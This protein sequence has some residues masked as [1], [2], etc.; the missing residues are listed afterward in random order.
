M[1][2]WNGEP[3]AVAGRTALA[4][5]ITTPANPY[6]A[7]NAVNQV[8]AYLFGTGLVEPLDDL[9]GVNPPS[10]PELLDELAT[11][12][13]AS[14][15]DIKYLLKAIARTRV[16]QLSSADP[17]G[18]VSTPNPRLF[19]RAAVRALTGD[20]LYDSLC[21]AAGFDETAVNRQGPPG[22]VTRAE[23]LV[24]FGRSDRP[25]HAGRTILQSLLFMNGGL[26]AD[27]IEPRKGRML[28][29]IAGAPFLDTT[30]RIEALYLAAL[31]RRPRPDESQRLTDF[32]NGGGPAH[33]SGRAWRPCF[34]HC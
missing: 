22:G 21:L 24:R 8:W 20:Q 28:A 29:A 27:A 25:T 18:S 16:Y 13:V 19:G 12:F 1:P 4:D 9:S 3:D 6:F 33:D 17:N 2:N 7:R 30:G 14:G 5:W 32:V 11:A 26:V 10:H 31:S 34:G 15:Y 23:F